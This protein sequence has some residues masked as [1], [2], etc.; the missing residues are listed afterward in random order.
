[1]TLQE[2]VK[3]M[4]QQRNAWQGVPTQLPPEEPKKPK[5]P[6]QPIS[7]YQ[8][9]PPAPPREDKLSQGIVQPV[10][11]PMQPQEAT[12]RGAYSNY[13]S[14]PEAS[15]PETPAQEASGSY[16]DILRQYMPK[17][18]YEQEKRNARRAQ[19]GAFIS[20]LANVVGKAG[21]SAGGAW[22]IEP[23]QFRTP[24]AQAQYQNVLDRE[25][26][27]YMDYGGR[28]ASAAMKDM[29]ARKAADALAAQNEW[30]RFKFGVGVQQAQQKLA[31]QMDKD[32]RD[33]DLAVKK[34]ERDYELGKISAKQRDR[35]IAEAARHNRAAEANARE[36]NRIRAEKEGTSGGKSTTIYL[37]DENG[38]K[39]AVTIPKDRVNSVM[40]YLARR[41]KQGLGEADSND[42]D[43]IMSRFSGSDSNS[44]LQA[45]V[46]MFGSEIPGLYEETTQLIG[47]SPDEDV[48]FSQ[49][50]R[51]KK[52]KAKKP[53]D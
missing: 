47:E 22:M 18:D 21:A 16:M 2:E 43:A 53:L 8:N 6:E 38:N 13:A 1:M 28:L 35:Q 46:N 45:V 10:T 34:A 17:P 49:W 9:D 23:T 11:P 15:K 36:A 31:Y 39:K 48:D 4:Q 25:K 5:P 44:K 3:R 14:Q 32:K 30:D 29:E 51:D 40:G 37:Q 27:A 7:Y 52:P 19:M 12:Y 50:K 20:D 33:Y 26:A 42:Y 24:A 41:V